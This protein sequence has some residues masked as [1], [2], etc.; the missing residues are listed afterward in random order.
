MFLLYGN[1]P[2][3]IYPISNVDF[4]KILFLLFCH[5]FLV[6]QISVTVDNKD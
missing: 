3:V 4:S 1:D 6:C 2:Q 5:L